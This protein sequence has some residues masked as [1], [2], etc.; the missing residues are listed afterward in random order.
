METLLIDFNKIIKNK[1]LQLLENKIAP[2]PP[3]SKN[4]F[5]G[6]IFIV[7]PTQL[8][9]LYSVDDNDKI[10]Y[11]NSTKFLSGI[12]TWVY[13]LYDKTKKICE[14]RGNPD[15]FLPEIT[16]V[17]MINIPNDVLLWIGVDIKSDKLNYF[18]DS[19]ISQGFNSPFITK[20]GPFGYTF[21][22]YGLCMI[23][24]NNVI[25]KV[26]NISN[27]IKYVLTQFL[28]LEYEACE[29][30][31][32]FN[33]DSIN[34]LQ[35]VTHIGSTIN[36]NGDI[37]QKEIAGVLEVETISEDLTHILKIKYN[38]IIYGEEEGVSIAQGLYNFHSHP[39]S[40]Y[41]RHNVKLAWPS[42]QDYIGYILA[43]FEDYTICHFVV[44]VEGIYI[45]SMT[46]YWLINIKNI[47]KYIGNFITEKY[48]FCYEPGQ[49]SEWYIKTVNSISY[50]GFPLFDVKY[51]PWD[52]AKE[53]FTV[54]YR[55]I[56]SNCFAE[57]NTLMKYDF[58][59]N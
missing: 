40:A 16:S 26:S 39:I 41:K 11:I 49:T 38:S 9:Y 52:K 2:I 8:D 14:I 59:Y 51:L 35:Q 37:S 1:K 4:Q 5:L 55:T 27:E 43:V 42:A 32:Q 45:V 48:D 23:K 7:S 29:V 17:I 20:S 54:K 13:I 53:S 46:T 28:L 12:K 58:I 50:R 10:K 19:Y 24:P 44:G 56:N 3:Y 36:K 57:E 21:D 18:I 25:P 15:T 47:D 22:N 33:E 30:T 6:I 34:Y 31:L